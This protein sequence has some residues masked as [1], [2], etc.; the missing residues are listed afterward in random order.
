MEPLKAL[1]HYQ[2]LWQPAIENKLR[3]TV[4]NAIGDDYAPLRAMLAYHLGW[5]GEGAG[6]EA[7]GKRIRPLLAL[8][9]CAAAGGDWH[10]ALPA[11]AAV[12]LL[13]NFSLIHDDIQDRSEVRRGRLTL[14]VKWGVPQA[15]NAGDLMFTLAHLAALELESQTVPSIVIEASQLLHRT[16]VHLTQGQFLDLH[17]ETSS[18]LALEDYWRMVAGKTAALLGCCTELGALVADV[19]NERRVAF[20]NFGF[21]LGLAFQVLDDWLG[22]WGDS[23][24]TGKSTESDLVTGKKTLPVLYALAKNDRFAEVWRSGPVDPITVPLLAEMLMEEGAAEFTLAEADRLTN[25]AVNALEAAVRDGEDAAD[26]LRG[27]T[28]QL[29]HRRK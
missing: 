13:H 20:Y 22:I 15:I 17:N 14:W 6:A 28:D 19:S 3:A 16:C 5:E 2:G 21:N 23:D 8:L 1:K 7:Q 9:S 11:A 25:V 24:Q 12:E 10:R 29:L 27:L 4:F 18:Q 26:A